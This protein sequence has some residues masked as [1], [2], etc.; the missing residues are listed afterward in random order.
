MYTATAAGAIATLAE[1]MGYRT[2]MHANDIEI[3]TGD[4]TFI[5]I[6][7]CAGDGRFWGSFDDYTS[8]HPGDITDP[9]DLAGLVRALAEHAP[10]A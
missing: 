7:K 4:D 3:R 2:L 1:S 6:M 8:I 9:D 10:S 5:S